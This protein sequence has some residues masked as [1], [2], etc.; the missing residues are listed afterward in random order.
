MAQAPPPA[1]S[2]P[3]LPDGSWGPLPCPDSPPTCTMILIV[4]RGWWSVHKRHCRM[5]Q[6]PMPERSS[7]PPRLQHS[8]WNAHAL[9]TAWPPA[10]PGTCTPPPPHLWPL[11]L[12]RFT[13]MTSAGWGSL[14]Y[15]LMWRLLPPPPGDLDHNYTDAEFTG[16]PEM[17]SFPNSSFPENLGFWHG[18]GDEC[19]EDKH[20]FDTKELLK[21]AN[22]ENHLW[23]NVFFWRVALGIWRC[24]CEGSPA[25]CSR[26]WCRG[27]GSRKARGI[28]ARPLRFVQNSQGFGQFNRSVV[29]KLMSIKSMMPSSHL[30]LCRPLLLPSMFPSIRVFSKES[31][32]CIRWPKYWSHR[33]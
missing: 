26:F 6:K 28:A 32:L 5:L 15:R 29:L 17:A 20:A 3:R 10:A 13:P 4:P 16:P 7:A 22:F 19:K 18:V 31:V 11:H 33:G 8:G 21:T 25:T 30:I 1:P 23:K 14:L 9:P 24:P 27:S 2:S 12:G